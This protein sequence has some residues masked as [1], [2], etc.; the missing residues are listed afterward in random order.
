[1][2]KN[3]NFMQELCPRA[4]HDLLQLVVFFELPLHFIKEPLNLDKVNLIQFMFGMKKRQNLGTQRE[5]FVL[6]LWNLLKN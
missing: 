6:N 2:E 1:M 3:L 4:V 5:D